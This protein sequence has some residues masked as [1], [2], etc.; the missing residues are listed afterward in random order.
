MTTK[1]RAI[2]PRDPPVA[3]SQLFSFSMLDNLKDEISLEKAVTAYFV[4]QIKFDGH[5]IPPADYLR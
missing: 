3:E 5:R 2:D 1:A 4:N